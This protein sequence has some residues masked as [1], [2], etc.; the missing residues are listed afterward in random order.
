MQQYKKQKLSIDQQIAHMRETKGI[1]FIVSTEDD[2]KDFLQ[3]SNYYFR[4][5]SYA[6][7]Y[8][9]FQAPPR[10]GKYI[11]LDFAYLKELSIIDM[12]FKDIIHRILE[13]IEHFAKL[14][15]VNDLENNPSEDG[16]NIVR[17][18]FEDDLMKNKNRI[19]NTISKHKNSYCGN[20]INKYCPSYNPSPNDQAFALWNVEEVLSFGDFIKLFE[21]Y[22][23]KYPS[24]TFDIIKTRSLLWSARMLRNAVAHDNCLLNSV[25]TG[26]VNHNFKI[27][28][29]LNTYIQK[30]IKTISQKTRSSKL[31][32][33]VIHDFVASLILFDEIVT[34][35]EIK[36]SRIN[37]LSSFINTRCRN[38]K[39]YFEKNLYL[40]STYQFI[41]KIVDYYASVI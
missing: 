38:H 32:N 1:K 3:T 16:Y 30:N 11:N 19:L 13:A 17:L 37:E 6:K 26:Y 34:S 18:F 12:H 24:Q 20:L 40:S 7:N 31:S 33:P 21:F 2:A 36:K 39:E 4:V 14:Q 5:K 28:L 8:D 41:K 25:R 22:Y 15:I 9:K 35:R 27:N 10:E 23:T 29:Y